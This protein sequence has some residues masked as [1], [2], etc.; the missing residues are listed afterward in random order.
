MR[1]SISTLSAVMLYGAFFLLE[2][3][4]VTAVENTPASAATVTSQH[5]SIQLSEAHTLSTSGGRNPTVAVD[6]NNGAVYTVWA[7]DE[8]DSNAHSTAASGNKT[9]P[10]RAAW[11]VRSDDGG[12]SF[13]PPLTITPPEDDVRS[14]T[15]SPTQVAVG[16]KSEVYVL[17][18]RKETDFTLPDGFIRG[19]NQLRLTRSSDGGKTFATPV[20]VA[21]E[22]VE[23][24]IGSPG[25][26]NLFVAENGD[27]YASWLDYRETF[28]YLIKEKK[29][30][31]K[32]NTLA[33]QLRVARSSDGGLSFAASRLVTKPVCGCCGTKV[34]QG[35]NS[36]LFASTRGAWP[37]LKGSVDAVR[38]IILS[39]S[40]DQG[41]N[42]STAVKVHDDRFKISACPDVAPGLSVDSKGRLHAAWYTGTERH[43]GIY[44]AVSDDFGQ[45]FSQPIA[46]LSDDWVPYADVK[47]ALDEHDNAWVAFEDRR[48]ET[49][50]VHLVRV[51]ADGTVIRAE[52]WPGTIPDVAAYGDTAVV[53]W[54]GIS[55]ETSE[56]D[57]AI[58]L[59]TARAGAGS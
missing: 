56:P 47:L 21:T 29:Q 40:E 5:P 57:G 28:S 53:A 2:C 19:R 23:E 27:L 58:R 51:T 25:M 17:Y 39:T 35:H 7:Q 38:D 31:P 34:A 24:A 20:D 41:K 42:W 50:L 55:A 11:L 3:A 44:Y 26:I 45:S 48:G 12:Q 6:K 46:L 14:H 37:E 43:P 36:P 15:V 32:G 18:N 1:L 30:P 8:I 16:P 9:D 52:P 22:A 33:T 13:S 4:P 10:K 59:R 49:D 54:G